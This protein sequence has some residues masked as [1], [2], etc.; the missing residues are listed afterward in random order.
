MIETKKE[1]ELIVNK[2]FLIGNGFD[3]ALGLKTR[4]SDFLLWML[5]R[6]TLE[7]Y[8][9]LPEDL[10]KEFD[11][12]N[13]INNINI[14]N[15]NIKALGVSKNKLFRLR[16]NSWI[17]N[18]NLKNLKTDNITHNLHEFIH[19]Y[20]INIES[21]KKYGII[22]KILSSKNLNWVD[23]EGI[24]FDI[25]KKLARYK[26]PVIK[27]SVSAQS[28]RTISIEELNEE[29][30]EI[31]KY[32]IEYLKEIELKIDHRKANPYARQFM[33][34]PKNRELIDY[35]R[36][37]KIQINTNHFYFLNFNYTPS[38]YILLDELIGSSKAGLKRKHENQIH[39]NLDDEK[40]IIFGFGDEMDP[41]YKEIE[42]LN[43]NRFFQHIKSFKYFQNNK[44]RH[45]QTFLN[46]GIYQVCV[47]GHSCGLS[48]RVMLN[49]IF[50]HQNCKSIKIYYYD[51]ADFVTKTMEISR[52]FNNKQEMRKRIVEKSDD[53]KIP[54]LSPDK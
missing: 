35:S 12:S 45:L 49:E 11:P 44:Q 10:Q 51:D 2:L 25:L 36:D 31:T 39:G 29:L 47:Y 8:N 13:P 17:S 43:D 9:K 1:N 30:N 26:E 6:A 32:L 5:K 27:T 28:K 34:T 3:L 22:E 54:Q 41:V 7:A 14:V 40:S 16:L 38:L 24:F 20:N 15:G 33:Q 48:D 21:V 42:E 4:Y 18:E 19:D 52:H 23:I 37:D 50:E 46:S 53:C